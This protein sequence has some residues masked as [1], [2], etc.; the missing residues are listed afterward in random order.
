MKAVVFTLGCKVNEVESSSLMSALESMGFEVTDELC[1][2]DIYVLNTCA[3]TREAEKKSRQLV[4][5]ARR[6]N[7]SALVYVCGCASQKDALQFAERGVRYVCG[8]RNKEALIAAAAADLSLSCPSGLPFP[9]QMRTRA[10]VKIEDGCNNFCSYCVIPYLRGR[11]TSRPIDDILG[12]IARVECPERVLTGINISAYGSDIGTDLTALVGAL[13][14]VDRRI[15]LGSLECNI[16]DVRFLSACAALK[17]F[18]PQFHLSLQSGSDA[19]LKAMNRRYTS[20][21]YLKKVAALKERIPDCAVTTDLIVG[22]PGETDEDFNDTLALVDKVGFASAF[23]FVY[24]RREG[25]AAAKMPNQVPE[26]V[27]KARIMRLVDAVNAKTRALSQ[28][29]IGRTVEIL[30]EDYDGKRGLYMGRDEHGRMGYFACE[31]DMTGQFVNIKITQA[32]G[33]SLTGE[34]VQTV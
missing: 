31:K 26:E 32:N 8:A 9:K 34:L 3:V 22:F 2:A 25:T 15:R 7:P 30:C 19:V 11:V 21:D 24:S 20:A 23:T 27:S 33:I 16:I 5:R 14:G 29:Y 1:P 12:E 4:S 17:K 13:S 10:F 28:T 18:A 6:F